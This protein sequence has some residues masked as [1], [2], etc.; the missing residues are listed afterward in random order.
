MELKHALRCRIAQRELHLLRVLRDSH[1]E[2]IQRVKWDM[3][4]NGGTYGSPSLQFPDVC[5]RS[6]TSFSEEVECGKNLLAY[7]CHCTQR[8]RGH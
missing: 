6:V 5:Y 2:I 8:L 7:L 3:H 4:T 1:D